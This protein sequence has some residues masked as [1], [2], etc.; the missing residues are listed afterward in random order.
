MG[1]LEVLEYATIIS[2]HIDLLLYMYY[3]YNM[4]IRRILWDLLNF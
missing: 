2:I 1:I 3:N 4:Y